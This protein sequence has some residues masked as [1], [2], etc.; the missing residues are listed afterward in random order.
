[1]KNNYAE[2]LIDE[3]KSQEDMFSLGIPAMEIPEINLPS[4][5]LTNLKTDF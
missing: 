3:V 5:D 4:F 2:K 1:M